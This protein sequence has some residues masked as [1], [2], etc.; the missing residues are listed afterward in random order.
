MEQSKPST[1]YLKKGRGG[2]GKA[3]QCS[4]HQKKQYTRICK[5]CLVLLCDKCIAANEH[6]DCDVTPID[7]DTESI[8]NQLKSKLTDRI[9]DMR[10]GVFELHEM[11]VRKKERMLKK[12]NQTV[13]EIERY[14]SRLKEK[15]L[16]DLNNKEKELTNELKH[17]VSQQETLVSEHIGQC[18]R[19][20]HN[21]SESVTMLDNLDK[22][23]QNT[24]KTKSDYLQQLHKVS[25]DLVSYKT[26]VSMVE[27]TRDSFLVI[28]FIVNQEGERSMLNRKLAFVEV[29]NSRNQSESDASLERSAI[30]NAQDRQQNAAGGSPRSNAHG[31]IVDLPE[32]NVYSQNRRSRS[33]PRLRPM[34]EIHTERETP[35]D[36]ARNILT[37]PKS[38]STNSFLDIGTD[39]SISNP[40]P[41]NSRLP[42]YY[43]RHRNS[44]SPVHM[45][46]N[47]ARDR[48]NRHSAFEPGQNVRPDEAN[49]IDFDV[50]CQAA[51]RRPV[52]LR[53][54]P[55]TTT[56][57][58]IF[59]SVAEPQPSTSQDETVSTLLDSVAEPVP[60]TSQEGRTTQ[61][62]DRATQN[63]E[64]LLSTVATDDQDTGHS[65]G[66]EKLPLNDNE[67][68]NNVAEDPPPPYPGGSQLPVIP[69]APGELP[70]PYQDDS[71]PPPYV[72]Y[73]E[74]SQQSTGQPRRRLYGYSGSDARRKETERI[75][76]PTVRVVMNQRSLEA[77][78]TTNSDF[79]KL[80]AIGPIKTFTVNEM[81]DKRS[82]GIF[83]IVHHTEHSFLIVDRWNKKL[84]YFND[85]GISYGG[86]IFREEPWDIAKESDTIYAVTVPQLK[87]IYK[88]TANEESV[89]TTGMISTDR[90][91]ACLAYHAESQR[92]VCGQVPQF[93]EPVVDLI[94]RDGGQILSTFR[95]DNSGIS[96]FSYPRYVKVSRDGVIVVC[97]WNM[98]CLMLLKI[99]GTF[100]GKYKGSN[101]ILFKDPT[102]IVINQATD[103]IY[104][105]ASTCEAVH[106]ISLNCELQEVLRG[107]E[108]FRDGRAI[109]SL[110]DRLVIGCKNGLVNVFAT[111]SQSHRV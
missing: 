3:I 16:R 30:D 75:N 62:T 46:G 67:T 36:E 65:S 52:Y 20:R 72:Q 108:E 101:E 82:A 31:L 95:S 73:P 59:D 15:I 69:P 14:F 70:P 77:E 43:K 23:Y 47:Y 24:D 22:L 106:K 41:A 50:E 25:K 99:D 80:K 84:K 91:Y 79:R 98:K 103:S 89:K 44:P 93:G 7:S 102:G 71:P 49:L 110:G 88:L 63:D 38:A 12:R 53:S 29:L 78:N 21:L 55:P 66:S 92:Y 60:S 11:L 18:N 68:T 28:R 58:A 48:R 8:F 104:A 107:P 86:V 74:T 5:T 56:V 10:S 54:S 1:R 33:A 90:K 35:T 109:D 76:A 94:A 61:S 6:L 17:S 42:D 64:L 26:D 9:K 4:L 100:V 34:S 57:D 39:E 96:L 97:D 105:I 27:E 32:Q 13:A 85:N 81:Y 2:K 37:V 83:A 111:S 40:T 45:R 51:I 87:S 19:L